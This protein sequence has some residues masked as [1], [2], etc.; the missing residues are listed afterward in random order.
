MLGN[1]QVPLSRSYLFMLGTL[2]YEK[3]PLGIEDVAINSFVQKSLFMDY[4]T[5]LCP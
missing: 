4:T 5:T 1:T 2:L 3:M